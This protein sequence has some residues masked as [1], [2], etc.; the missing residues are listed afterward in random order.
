MFKLWQV[1]SLFVA[2]TNFRELEAIFINKIPIKYVLWI[3]SKSLNLDLFLT[4]SGEVLCEA[5]NN[6]LSKFEGVLK[7][8]GESFSLDNEKILLRGCVLRNTKWCY[9]MVVFA[10]QD[11]KLMMNSGKSKFKR[12][13]IDRLVNILIIGVSFFLL[14]T[15][16]SKVS[17]WRSVKFYAWG[18]L[19]MVLNK[20]NLL[21]GC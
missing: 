19:V 21:E 14:L 4:L 10:G 17:S 2:D 20:S 8:N 16:P 5:P 6:R 11:T 18:V 1:V 9:G 15:E 7:Y 13:H 12:T 3:L